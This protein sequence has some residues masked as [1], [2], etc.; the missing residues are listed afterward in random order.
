[1][2][3]KWALIHLLL[4]TVFCA[5]SVPPVDDPATAI[6]ESDLQ[7]RLA[8]PAPAAINVAPRA[9]SSDLPRL[10]RAVLI[11]ASH[12]GLHELSPVMKQHNPRS[13]QDLLCSLLL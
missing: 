13:P 1:M 5:S 9:D 8:M 6:D 12:R 2:M 11:G 7:V 3:R 4:L 10:T